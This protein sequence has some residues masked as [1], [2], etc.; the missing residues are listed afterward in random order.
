MY[1]NFS[2][3]FSFMLHTKLLSAKYGK[4]HFL[5]NLSVWL[6]NYVILKEEYFLIKMFFSNVESSV[7]FT[8]LFVRFIYVMWLS[9]FT[10]NINLL[11]LIFKEKYSWT[12]T[13]IHKTFHCISSSD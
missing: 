3:E 7:S 11:S 9:M 8:F 12:G 6:K 2:V 5:S 4:L 13:T 1:S 10:I